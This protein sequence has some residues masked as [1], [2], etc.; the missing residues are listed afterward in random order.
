MKANKLLRLF[1]G[2]HLI[3]M[4]RATD[5]D[6]EKIMDAVESLPPEVEPEPVESQDKKAKDAEVIPEPEDEDDIESQDRKRMH[7]ALDCM[8]DEP[9]ARDG[10]RR[11]RAKDADLEELK[12]LL[13][14]FFSEE[15]AEP[16]HAAD[17][18]EEVDPSQ[19]EAAL[20]DED[21]AIEEPEDE[22]V[23][24]S[25]GEPGEEQ[26]ES[27]E[28]ELEDEDDEPVESQ[29]RRKAKDRAKAADGAKETLR[30]LRPFVARVNDASLNKAFN[31]AL[32]VVTKKSRASAADGGYGGF[33]RAARA[34]DGAPRNPNP[35]AR[36]ADGAA[37]NKDK[38]LQAAYDAARGGK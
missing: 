22:D 21:P 28:E 14:Q 31:T 1:M 30:M 5:A 3:E 29:D 19:L 2:K 11:G 16:E 15:E 37:E 34:R 36:A 25:L 7:D 10:K 8:L 20:A 23:E 26:V 9:S 33:A 18:P 6:P 32:G 4:A 17:E 24:D 38:K 13:S 27:G 12:S 35:R